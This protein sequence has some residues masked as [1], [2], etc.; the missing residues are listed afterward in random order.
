MDR[1]NHVRGSKNS[2]LRKKRICVDEQ[3]PK[4]HGSVREMVQH[5]LRQISGLVKTD[6]LFQGVGALQFGLAEWI[7]DL[8]KKQEAHMASW[9]AQL[10]ASVLG[11][12]RGPEEDIG[13]CEH[14]PRPK[15]QNGRSLRTPRRIALCGKSVTLS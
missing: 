10:H 11:L 15:A 3:A 1:E 12:R 13:S 5:P 4:S 7:M 2:P 14:V 6:P 9:S 8:D